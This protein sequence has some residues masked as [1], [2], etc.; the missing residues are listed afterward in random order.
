MKPT[1]KMFDI[2]C[3][4]TE[5]AASDDVVVLACGFASATPAARKSH[6]VSQLYGAVLM[7]NGEIAGWQVYADNKPVYGLLSEQAC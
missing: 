1:N 3:I 6:C 4:D 2:R 5:A 7:T